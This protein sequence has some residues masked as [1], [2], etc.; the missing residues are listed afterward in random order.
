MLISLATKFGWKINQFKIKNY[1]V[2][3]DLVEDI[4]MEPPTSN[5]AQ[6]QGKLVEKLKKALYIWNCLE[7]MVWKIHT[8]HEDPRI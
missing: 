4:Y 3:G 2:H 1:L 5:K 6:E 8:N 7:I